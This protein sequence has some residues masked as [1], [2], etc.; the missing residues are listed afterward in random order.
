MT[1]RFRDGAYRGYEVQLRLYR[2]HSA[3]PVS[4]ESPRS[5]YEFMAELGTYSAEHMYELLFDRK[6][7][8]HGVYLVGK[9]GPDHCLA[10]PGEI[11][12]PALLTNSPAIVLV[13]NHPSGLPTPS[14]E[15]LSMT[16]RIATAANLFDIQLLDSII[17][18]DGRYHS[19]SEAGLMTR[20]GA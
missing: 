11:L 14:P 17:I 6:H 15:D 13:H 9:G 19:M 2:T 1:S 20:G 18:G 16:A 4:L 7:R 5:V 3:E 12:R 8:V 10:E